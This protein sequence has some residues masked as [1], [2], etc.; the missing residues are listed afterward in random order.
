MLTGISGAGGV[1][2]A[3]FLNLLENAAAKRSSVSRNSGSG[4]PPEDPQ[5]SGHYGLRWLAERVEALKGTLEIG[6]VSP[7]GV[8]LQVRLPLSASEGAA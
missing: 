8:R 2:G 1:G 5:R 6:R 3:A 7:H 4:M